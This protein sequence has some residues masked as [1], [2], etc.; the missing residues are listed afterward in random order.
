MGEV[1]PM[2]YVGQAFVGLTNSQLVA[3]KGTFVDDIQLPGM[4]YMAVLRSPYAHARIRAIDTTKAE[5]L[6]GVVCVTTGKDVQANMNPITEAYDTRA[7]GAKGVAWY[8][9]CPERVRFVGEAVAAVVAEHKY[10]AYEA[11]DLIDVDY[12][13]LP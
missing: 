7:M 13:E 6:P 12:E 8:S 11:L 1:G 10:T 5:E 2:K 4:T 3:G 9:L